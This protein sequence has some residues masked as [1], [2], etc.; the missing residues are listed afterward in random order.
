M[1]AA[2]GIYVNDE[3]KFTIGRAIR[4]REFAMIWIVTLLV[5]LIAPSVFSRARSRTRGRPF[6]F[7]RN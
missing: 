7:S 2:I 6:C 1:L 3:T 5:S 4:A